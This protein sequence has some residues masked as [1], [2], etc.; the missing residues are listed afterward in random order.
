M[1]D[2]NKDKVTVENFVD[3]AIIAGFKNVGPTYMESIEESIQRNIMI[4]EAG[5]A[6]SCLQEMIDSTE[7]EQLQQESAEQ[8]SEL[9]QKMKRVLGRE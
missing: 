6:Q 9:D 1:S 5:D 3:S 4:Q 7:T 8:L 2:E